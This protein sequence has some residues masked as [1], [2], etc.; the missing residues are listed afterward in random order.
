[1]LLE[2]LQSINPTALQVGCA[3]LCLGLG[4]LSGFISNMSNLT[5]YN[6]LNQPPFRPPNWLFGPVW[7]ALYIMMG[8]GFGSLITAGSR[9]LCLLFLV[10]YAINVAWSPVFFRFQKIKS[11]FLMICSMWV[12]IQI[13]IFACFSLGVN[14][15]LFG[16]NFP[17]AY[18]FLPY[19]TWISFA[20]ILNGAAWA[21]NP[22]YDG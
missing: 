2:T 13:M 15:D 22:S 10:Q 17:V 12:L 9:P 5:W 7:T 14:C 20:S 18:L 11:A 4:T 1:M 19:I 21:L 16:L 8:I 3:A 6:A